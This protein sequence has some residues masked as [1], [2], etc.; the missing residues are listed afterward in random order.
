MKKLVHTFLIF[1]VCI[2]APT[3]LALTNE[4]NAQFRSM[5]FLKQAPNLVDRFRI[6][7]DYSNHKCTSNIILY[8][9]SDAWWV[10]QLG[11]NEK[12]YP[13][14]EFEGDSSSLD[15]YGKLEAGVTSIRDLIDVAIAG[16]IDASK[17]I[18]VPDLLRYL[19]FCN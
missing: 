13:A 12:F 8:A 3:S 1:V 4:E 17:P 9:P 11:E 14:E 19:T 2:Y 18:K 10:G 5:K 15:A 6:E 16:E 7:N